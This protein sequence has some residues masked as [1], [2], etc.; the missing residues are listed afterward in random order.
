[1]LMLSGTM[2]TAAGGDSASLRDL[3]PTGVLGN[4]EGQGYPDMAGGVGGGQ[5]TSSSSTQSK[6]GGVSW[7]WAGGR[8]GAGAG[9]GGEAE[10]E[11]QKQI[12]C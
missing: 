4:P 12:P 5:S 9:G 3:E 1:M 7:Y 2:A 6:V 11:H 10:D 8:G